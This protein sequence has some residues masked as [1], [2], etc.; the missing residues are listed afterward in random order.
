MQPRAEKISLFKGIQM[1]GKPGRSGGARPGAGR[2]KKQPVTLPL[3]VH[4]DDPLV[5]LKAVMN[6]PGTE[7]KMRVDAAKALM[8]FVHVKKGEGGKKEQKQADAEKVASKFSQA[9]APRLAA[10]GGKKV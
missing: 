1:T 7:A 4:Y 3:A 8:P 2:P 10:A 5:F 9:A 6:D